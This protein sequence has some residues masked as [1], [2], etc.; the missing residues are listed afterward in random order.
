MAG[1][2]SNPS[3]YIFGRDHK[4]SIRLNYQH[5]LIKRLCNERLLH[6]TVQQS[7]GSRSSIRIADIATGTAIWLTELSDALPAD[8]QLHGFDVSGDQYP[9]KEWLPKNVSLHEH[10]AF[11]PFAPEFL[12]SF[13]VVNLRF[14]ITLLNGDNIQRL[15]RNLKTLLRPGGFLHWLDF[16]PRSAKA[17]STRPDMQMPRTESVVSVMR[18]AQPDL[19]LWIS[20]DSDLFEAAGLSPITYERIQLRKH[21]RPLWNDCHIMGME[22]LSRRISGDDDKPS[23]LLQQIK[24]LGA[25]FARGTSIDAQWFMMVGQK[26]GGEQ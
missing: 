18:T 5:M 11:A 24:D 1:S 8:S 19:D 10:D 16:D 13:D 12:G 6:Q 4:S 17:I 26:P 23:P 22:E 7:I 14:F 2:R 21:L 25:E 3:S 9:P 15:V 20:H